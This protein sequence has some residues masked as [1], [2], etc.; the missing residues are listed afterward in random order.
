MP[1][2]M[3]ADLRGFLNAVV[4]RRRGVRIH[5]LDWDYSLVF[6]L[7]RELLP[8]IRLGWRTHRRIEFHL[9]RMR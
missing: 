9:D 6:A 7:E 1:A 3:P 4:A 5:L 8:L 2:G